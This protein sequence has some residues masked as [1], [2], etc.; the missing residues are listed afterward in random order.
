LGDIQAQSLSTPEIPSSKASK[1]V[2][3]DQNPGDLEADKERD[4]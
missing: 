1:G 4:F 2:H 3:S